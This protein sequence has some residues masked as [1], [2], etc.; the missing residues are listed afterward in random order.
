MKYIAKS[1]ILSIII[2]IMAY[3]QAYNGT[4]G[5][6]PS[7]FNAALS[8]LTPSSIIKYLDDFWPGSY[9]FASPKREF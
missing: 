1:I 7:K 2:P 6:A 5:R 4:T 9:C 8:V 3:S